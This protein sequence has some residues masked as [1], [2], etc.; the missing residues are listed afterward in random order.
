MSCMMEYY[1]HDLW[2][3]ISRNDLSNNFVNHL[4]FWGGKLNKNK[5]Q[6][7]ILYIE[8]DNLNT[9]ISISLIFSIYLSN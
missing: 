7:L 5:K 4:L 3:K 6:K 8:S 2:P 1:I 9:D